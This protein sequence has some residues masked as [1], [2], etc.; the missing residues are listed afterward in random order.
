M[1]L[2]FWGAPGTGKTTALMG[3]IQELLN[4]SYEPSDF[5]I[6]T[7]RRTM[8]N[9]LRHRVGWKKNEGTV[10]TLH[11]ICK[12]LSEI[13]D[14]IS[15]RDRA[16]FCKKNGLRYR[17]SSSKYEQDPEHS[18]G[19]GTGNLFFDGYSYLKNTMQDT[20]GIYNYTNVSQ[21]ERQYPSAE[22]FMEGYTAKYEK[23]K[24][25]KGK[26]DFDDM[27]T[28]VYEEGYVPDCRVLIVD[29][30]QDLTP[31]QYK[32]IEQFSEGV[33]EFIVAGDPRQTI[34][35]F[36]GATPK[37][38]EELD[39]KQVVLSTSYRLPKPVWDYSAGLLH[40]V[41][42]TTPKIQTTDKAGF[43]SRV[44][45]TEYPAIA[46][47]FQSNAF[48]LVRTNKH[49]V[50]VA[51]VLSRLGIPFKGIAGWGAGQIALFNA[52]YKLRNISANTTLLPS[53]I[54]AL[55]TT[56]PKKFFEKKKTDI[57]FY[58]KSVKEVPIKSFV[59]FLSRDLTGKYTLLDM[60]K[61]NPFEDCLAELSNENSLTRR[62]VS[63]ALKYH[64]GLI[65][66][67]SVLVSTIHGVKGEEADYVFLHDELTKNIYDGIYLSERKREEEAMVFYVGSSRARKGLVVV[68]SDKF[69]RYP[70]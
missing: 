14:V 31:L 61:R 26:H 46:K 37:F 3:K 70:L 10:N 13:T 39:A 18:G 24:R 41:Y 49:G 55:L 42:L 63:S 38:F 69:M 17:F 40:D 6:T 19:S 8:A 67:I 32:I 27:L 28:I 64:K 66:D 43:V 12:A 54:N 15:D 21:I 62:K 45:M 9:E 4:D 56:Y 22:G 16:E 35:S 44:S 7:F 20:D 68:E 25:E 58:L 59:R 2:K 65:K 53:E 50:R 29:E 1:R 23:F 51:G 60:V 5:C 30:F 36:W 33:D 47:K 48:H 34:Y 11:G 52:I 57:R